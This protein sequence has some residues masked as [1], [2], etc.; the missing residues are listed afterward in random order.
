MNRITAVLR[1]HLEQ[2]QR[3][4]GISS[5]TSKAIFIAPY[6]I[7][8][9]F[10]FLMAYPRTQD[11]TELMTFPSYPIEWA[12]FFVFLGAGILSWRLAFRLRRSG[13]HRFIW[14]FYL[15]F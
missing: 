3:E 8:G 12:M 5:A 13:E 2:A 14:V 4:F 1:N 7:L 10:F 6:L 15:I 9:L 11:F